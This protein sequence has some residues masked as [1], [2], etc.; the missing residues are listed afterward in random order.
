M[1]SGLSE[2]SDKC[3]ASTL[4]YCLGVD[5]EDVLTTTHISDDNRKKY[6]KVL[7]K[8][9]DFFRVRLLSLKEPISTGET[10]NLANQQKIT[11]EFYINLQAV[12]NTAKLKR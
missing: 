2:K 7:K 5:A 8:F 11:E 4:L 12:V 3:Q 10:N 6:S 1:A 9:D